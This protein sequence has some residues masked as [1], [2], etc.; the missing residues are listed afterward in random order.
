MNNRVDV[1]AWLE[2]NLKKKRFEHVMGVLKVSLELAEAHGV[3]KEKAEIAALF[4]DYAKNFSDEEMLKRIEDENLQDENLSVCA[5]INLYHGIVGASIAEKEY[6]IFD[7]DILNAIE[8]H[9]FGRAGMSKLEKITYLSDMTEPSRN[10]KGVEEIR[11]KAFLDLDKAMVMAIDKTLLYLI[12][13]GEAININ[14][15]FARNS[16]L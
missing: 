6:G 10:F 15:I 8:H 7:R 16:L 13:R 2:A 1:V 11:E 4:H 12:G 9:T 14:T 3:S 5:S